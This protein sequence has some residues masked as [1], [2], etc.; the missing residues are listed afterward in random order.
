MKKEMRTETT[1]AKVTKMAIRTYMT[2]TK[3]KIMR[4]KYDFE[5]ISLFGSLSFNFGILISSVTVDLIVIP[6][7]GNLD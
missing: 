4:I 1:T 7:M 5:I 6:V 3:M 2:T